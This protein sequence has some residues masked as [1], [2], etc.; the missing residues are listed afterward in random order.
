MADPF[1]FNN[2][3]VVLVNTT[4]PGNI[5]A[6]ARAMKTMSLS[7]LY[8]VAPLYF[9]HQE[10]TARASGADEILAQAIVSENLIS[11]L[12]GC[13]LV[14][15]TTARARGLSWPVCDPR[16]CAVKI[17]AQPQQ[18]ISSSIF[19]NQGNSSNTGLCYNFMLKAR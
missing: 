12:Q 13:Q 3:R 9:P 8:L 18:E 10:A 1:I 17:I 6:A 5:G 19:H 14:F 16:E 4:H 7:R 11:A 2:I 15:A